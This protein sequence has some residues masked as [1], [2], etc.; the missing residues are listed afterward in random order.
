METLKTL[1]LAAMLAVGSLSLAAC[2]DDEPSIEDAM[3][4]AQDA[5]EDAAEEMNDAMDNIGN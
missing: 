4:E 5:A 1:T 2:G 3:E